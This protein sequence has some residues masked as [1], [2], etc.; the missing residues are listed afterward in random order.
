MRM[1]VQSLAFSVGLGSGVAVSCGVG[2]GCGLD[3]VLLW[4]W[5]RST[6]AAPIQPLASELPYAA[7]AVLKRKQNNNGLLFKNKNKL[8][9]HTFEL[10]R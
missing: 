8:Q 4:L 7:G 9:L 2:C 10:K 1:Q 3:L 6:A 5:R